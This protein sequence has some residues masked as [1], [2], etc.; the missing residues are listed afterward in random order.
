[1]ID[2]IDNL[3]ESAIQIYD[4]LKKAD[5]NVISKS[6]NTINSS[7]D[8]VQTIDLVANDILCEGLKNCNNIKEI[9]SEEEEDI[10]KVNNNGEYL[11]SLDPLDG[12]QN[13]EVNITCGIIF[14]IYRNYPIKNGRNIICSGYFLFSSSL[15]L[16]ITYQ[17]QPVQLFTYYNEKW[18]FDKN[19]IIPDK[20]KIY[21]IN[22]GKQYEW[23][24]KSVQIFVEILKRQ[25]R[26]IRLAACFVTEVHRI[27]QQGGIFLYPTDKKC[28]SG[29]LRLLYE[30]FPMSFIVE[31]AGGISLDTINNILDKEIPNKLHERSPIILG[32]KKDVELYK[33]IYNLF[34]LQV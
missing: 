34:N 24:S 25:N 14:G 11:V 31:N 8:N 13:I 2:I 32:S 27:L 26:S 20:N 21:S 23:N 19:L 1:M 30:C 6:S 7:G 15:Q 18:R 12:S 22:E 16:I 4:I 17:E 29:K 10:I 3:K 28:P 9:V 5:P 33:T